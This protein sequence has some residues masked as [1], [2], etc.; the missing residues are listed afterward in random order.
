MN[1]TSKK[2]A[3][4][5]LSLGLVLPL[6]AATFQNPIIPDGADPW[7]LFRNGFYHYTQTTGG[8]VR[9]RKA[10]TLTGA[11]GL[12]NVA[13]TTVFTP[14]APNNQNVWAPELHFLQGKWYV[15]FAADDG[16]N[17]NHRMYVAEANSSNPQGAYTSKGKIYDATTDRWAIDGTV[18]EKPD[19]SLYFI[20]SGWPGSTDGL[21]NL[22]IA[23]MSNPWTIS[24]PRVL[25]ST[26]TYSW[27]GWINEG[28]EI[29]QRNGKIFIVYS[30]N[31]SWTDQYCFGL[32]TCTN[33]DV[34]NASS[35]TKKSTSIF[36]K[37]SDAN[38]GVYGPG[39]GSFT[40]S[41]DQT[42]DWLIYHAAK[43]SGTGWDRSVRLQKFTWNADDSPNFGNPFPTNLALN[44]P[45]G[46]GTNRLLLAATLGGSVAKS[47]NQVS[48]PQNASAMVTA[49]PAPGFFFT[50]WQGSA[51][52]F[53]NPLTVTMDQDLSITA[54]FTNEL[55]LDN[56]RAIFNG[57]WS[58][59]EISLDKFGVDYRFAHVSNALTHT[60][61]YIPDL[62]AAAKYDIHVWYP[63]GTNR[64]TNAPYLV[65]CLNGAV[66]IRLNQQSNGGGWRLLAAGADFAP[67][68]NGFV[69]LGNNAADLGK[70]VMADAVR[71]TFSTNLNALPEF[72]SVGVAVPGQLRLSFRGNFGA[73]NTVETSTNLVDWYTWTNLVMTGG[74]MELW[75]WTT[76][77]PQRFYRVRGTGP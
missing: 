56:S 50:G 57:N 65:S 10:A 30:A 18:L 14:A 33:G 77:G 15:Y 43:A 38:G 36:K 31:A 17:A 55:V 23:P 6:S 8:S 62:P 22:Y 63:Q 47:P 73:T 29:I 39:H 28:P 16:D 69:R 20:W 25:I 75:D 66:T 74:D 61:T 26:P 32:L 72:R 37:Y 7:I 49:T 27:E 4:S 21:Q 19:G 5:L 46:E 40:K 42:E 67:G 58:T 53:T 24:G 44:V 13:A 3:A 76:N 68:T 12:G 2:I 51:T 52:G 60:A 64:S 35:W 70:V 1:P 71:F 11:T 41:L 45:S 54:V 59:G 34:L 9:V 48:F